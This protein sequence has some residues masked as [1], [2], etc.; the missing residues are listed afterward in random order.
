MPDCSLLQVS[1]KTGDK[2]SEAFLAVVTSAAKLVKEEEPILPT[3]I[4]LAASK[5]TTGAKGKSDQCAC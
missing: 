2:V 3:T 1:A 4:D 5:P